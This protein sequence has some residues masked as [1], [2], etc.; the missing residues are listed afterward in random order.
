SRVAHAQIK[1][2]LPA[3]KF[4]SRGAAVLK[5]LFALRYHRFPHPDANGIYDAARDM[6]PYCILLREPELKGP[7]A[8]NSELR[9]SGSR[10][11]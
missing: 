8:P 2:Q 1:A 9:K 6:L 5:E 11:D 3:K 10:V 4:I 7:A